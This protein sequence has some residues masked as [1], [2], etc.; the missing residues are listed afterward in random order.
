MARSRSR[1]TAREGAD[2]VAETRSTCCY[3]G[4]GCGV[5]IEHDGRRITGVRGDPEHPANFGKL[6]SKGSTLHLT[7]QPA[8]QRYR[9]T[10]PLV[11]RARGLP[12]RQADWDTNARFARGPVRRSAFAR[13]GRTA[14]RSTSPAS[15]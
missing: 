7:A 14:S 12:L 8:A 6:C 2:V 9:A 15:S 1:W 5:V 4:V 10:H 3:C 13:M 11:R